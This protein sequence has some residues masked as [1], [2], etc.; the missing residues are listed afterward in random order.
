MSEGRRRA[1]LLLLAI[2]A[3]A[4]IAMHSLVTGVPATPVAAAAEKNDCHHEMPCDDVHLATHACVGVLAGTLT[5]D[6]DDVLD[7]TASS[8]DSVRHSA[9][10]RHVDGRWPPWTT[11]TSAQLSIWR[12]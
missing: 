4:L 7:Q 12:V 3:P 10:Y 2:L 8:P 9:I 1:L 11:P 5:V 6:A